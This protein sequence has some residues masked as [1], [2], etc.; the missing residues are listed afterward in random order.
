MQIYLESEDVGVI[1]VAELDSGRTGFELLPIYAAPGKYIHDLAWDPTGT[2]FAVVESPSNDW[3]AKELLIVDRQSGSM[4]DGPWTPQQV[5]IP[6]TNTFVF[7]DWARST[8]GSRRIASQARFDPSGGNKPRW[9][10]V[11]IDFAEQDPQMEIV[12]PGWS[13]SWSPDDRYLVFGAQ[14]RN[15][16]RKI[17]S[18]VELATGVVTTLG[19]TYTG[20]GSPGTH[21][22]R[23][24]PPPSVC[25]DDVC[26]GAEDQC[27]CPDDCGTP[28]L[29]ELL[30]L[31]CSDEIDNDC[32]GDL[33]CDD[34]DCTEDPACSSGCVDKG[35]D[36]TSSEQCCSGLCHP[37][38]KVCK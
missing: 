15:S 22:S 14:K 11:I 26:D 35:F 25:G 29:N 19:G 2:Q 28:P 1:A 32:D 27:N 23:A 8:S 13:P 5:G 24:V 30:F 3:D 33:D 16:F 17:V 20:G 4:V 6:S 12:V 34:I 38:K 37:K 10:I 21:W 7:L 18:R 9:W 31:E 36:C